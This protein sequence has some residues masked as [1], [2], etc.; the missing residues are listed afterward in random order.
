[1]SV[2]GCHPFFL[3]RFILL[4]I[5]KVL[6]ALLCGTQVRASFF[7]SASVYCSDF[8]SAIVRGGYAD[9]IGLKYVR[10]RTSAHMLE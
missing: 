10:Q 1:M 7:V 5:V 9:E 6:R 3:R 4:V 8:I 2:H